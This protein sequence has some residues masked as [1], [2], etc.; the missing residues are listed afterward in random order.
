MNSLSFL[1]VDDQMQSKQPRAMTDNSE[2]CSVH[3]DR[4][5]KAYGDYHA[6]RAVS[7]DV[8]AGEFLTLL[9]PSGS[10]KTT[11]LMVIAGFIRADSGS[12]LFGNQEMIAVPPHKRNVGIVFQNYALFPHMT[13]K[14]NVDYPLKLRGVAKR[15]REQR[16]QAA[17]DLVKLGTVGDRKPDALSGGQRQRVALAR[18]IVFEPRVLLMDEPLSALDKNLREAMQ[19]EI[20]RL[21]ERLGVTT[22]YVT[23]DQREALTMSDRIAVMKDGELAQVGTPSDIYDSPKTRFVGTFI[24]ESFLMPLSWHND[25]LVL[26]GQPLVVAHKPDTGITNP[27][28]LVR[29]ERLL[30]SVPAGDTQINVIAAKL[31]DTVYQGDTVLLQLTLDSG[32][33]IGVR[34]GARDPQLTTLPPLGARLSIGLK[35]EDVIVVDDR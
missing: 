20:R 12:L 16:V 5:S 19:I 33:E 10:G 11:L 18:C 35:A 6:L 8:R 29:P 25:A 14:E 1:A 4:V 28:L 3:I 21:H 32:L 31:C 27:Y 23:H 13:V 30:L 7:L 26:N 17:L 24:G 34:V 2:P 22:I 15:E 9:G